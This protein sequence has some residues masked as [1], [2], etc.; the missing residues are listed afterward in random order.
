MAYIHW[1]SFVHWIV[2]TA[3][4]VHSVSGLCRMW[5]GVCR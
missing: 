2:C 3:G 1:Y 4:M 5:I